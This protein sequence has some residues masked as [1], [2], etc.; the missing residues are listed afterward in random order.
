[1]NHVTENRC[2]SD[3]RCPITDIPLGYARY[4]LPTGRMLTFYEHVAPWN[5]KLKKA[6][7]S[8]NETRNYPIQSFATGDIVPLFL[9]RL[10]RRLARRSE[11]EIWK[12]VHLVNTVHDS[13]ELDVHREA[14]P[15]LLK[16][17]KNESDNMSEYMQKYFGI[18]MELPLR[19][20]VSYGSNW[21]EQT[22]VEGD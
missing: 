1:M 18:A 5:I 13:V 20:K 4:Q 9:G 12:R 14:L 19:T 21:C 11:M 3:R 22:E 16:V 6:T 7:F 15:E 8:P 2:S 10:Y 17:L